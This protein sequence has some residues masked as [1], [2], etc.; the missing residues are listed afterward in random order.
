MIIENSFSSNDFSDPKARRIAMNR[1]I[2]T[3]IDQ[4][5]M[6]NK[7]MFINNP[8]PSLDL[9]IISHTLSLFEVVFS[10]LGVVLERESKLSAIAVAARKKTFIVSKS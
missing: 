7:M 3:K 8:R 4:A 5:S 10:E 1:S 9:L 6:M 2:N